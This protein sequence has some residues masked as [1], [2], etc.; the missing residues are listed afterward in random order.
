MDSMLK[1]KQTDDPHDVLVVSSDVVPVA[2]ANEQLSSVLQD[3]ARLLADAQKPKEKESGTGSD[4]PASPPVPADPPVPPVPPVDITFRPAAVDDILGRRSLGQRVIRA[5]TALLLAACIG[6]AALAWQFGG[7]LTKKVIGKWVP[8]LVLT[9]SALQEKLGLSAPPAPPADAPAA[10][11]AANPQAATPEAV[12]AQTADTQAAAPAPESAASA[13]AAPPPE[14]TPSP[15][16]MARDL[17]SLGQEVEQLKASIDQLKAGQQQMSLDIA[18][19][20]GKASEQN[21]RPR[22]SPPVRRPAVAQARKPVPPYPLP[23]TAAAHALPQAAA[24]YPAAAPYYAPR[25]PEPLPA[26]T[27]PQPDPELSSVPRPPMPVQ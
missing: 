23:Q 27:Q 26:T 21:P 14:T 13:T 11:E 25:Q 10:V 7:G 3:A 1:S 15:Q 18:K 22:I 6:V 2:P 8:Q 16:S 12:A 20:S 4:V 5:F 24:S 19:A 9:S 17:A